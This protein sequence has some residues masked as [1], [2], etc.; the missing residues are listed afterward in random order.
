MKP[1]Y[2]N[3]R[4]FY[5]AGGAIALSAAAFLV[6][7]AL[8]E[9]V[10]YFY[11]PLEIESGAAVGKDRIRL[12]GL[13]VEGTLAYEEGGAAARFSVTDGAAALTVFYR[14]VFPDLFREG[15]G[16]VAQGRF[17]EEGVFI[18]DT[19]LA[20]H[21]ENYRPKE[22]EEALAKGKAAAEASED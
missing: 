11:S 14:G 8:K 12:G 16:V 13:V 3:K 22:L 15:Q 4:L 2:R 19:I 20:K 1:R 18:A 7:S 6:F 21:D 5:L 10:A 9:N 17:D